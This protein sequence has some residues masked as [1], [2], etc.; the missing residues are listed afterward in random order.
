MKRRGKHQMRVLCG[1]PYIDWHKVKT[2]DDILP[3]L[4]NRDQWFSQVV[5]DE[6]LAKH[7][8][9][10]VVMGAGH[11]LRGRAEGQMPTYIEPHLRQAGAKTYL[12]MFGTNVVGSYDDLDHRFDR[13][14][15]PVVVSLAGNWVGELPTMPVVTGGEALRPQFR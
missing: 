5:K 12:I 3:Y 11:F 1:D 14:P 8:R 10:L 6:V 7:H 2:R 4:S 13:W 15:T 9:A